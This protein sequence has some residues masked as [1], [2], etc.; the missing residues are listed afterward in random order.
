MLVQKKWLSILSF[1]I[2]CW[3]FSATAGAF[4]RDF[5]P[6]N[7]ASVTSGSLAYYADCVNEAKERWGGVEHLDRRM[8]YRCRGDVAVSYF[9]Y[10]GRQRIRDIRERQIAGVFIFRIIRG[11]GLCWNKIE[12]ERGRPMSVYGCD[13]FEQI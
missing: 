13:I 5:G 8:L 9:N 4:D 2:C 11:K 6:E 3:S 7:S 10:L 1:A 12:D